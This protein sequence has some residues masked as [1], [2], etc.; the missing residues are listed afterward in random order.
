[1]TFRRLLRNRLIS[2][3][4]LV[5]GMQR[6]TCITHYALYYNLVTYLLIYNGAIQ[7]CCEQLILLGR[8]LRSGRSTPHGL[9]MFFFLFFARRSPSSLDRWP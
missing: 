3:V 9:V 6:I 5:H 8:P 4:L 7:K 1:M 2:R